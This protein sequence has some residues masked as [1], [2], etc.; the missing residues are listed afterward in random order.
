MDLTLLILSHDNSAYGMQGEKHQKRILAQN[1]DKTPIAKSL[2]NTLFMM[3]NSRY[4][5]APDHTQCRP[6]PPSEGLVECTIF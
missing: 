5:D 3:F 4:R 2:F 1:S 6:H